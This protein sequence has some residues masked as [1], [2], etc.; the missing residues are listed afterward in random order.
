MWR[1]G[2]GVFLFS[3]NRAAWRLG[4][5]IGADVVELDKDLLVAVDAGIFTEPSHGTDSGIMQN[6]ISGELHAYGYQLG[7]SLRKPLTPWLAPYVR[8]GFL[9]SKVSMD[10]TGTTL[11]SSGGATQVQWSRSRWVPGGT[12]GLG[13]MGY[14]PPTHQF[15]FGMLAEGGYWLQRSVDIA[16]DS[17][18]PNGAI[19]TSGATLGSLHNSGP[20]LRLAAVMRF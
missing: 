7:A 5:G 3:Q 8:A 20:Y 4:I 18:L 2:S 13:V 9:T 11:D 17:S 1:S 19:A 6:T 16:L 15:S 10:I 14:T 12:L